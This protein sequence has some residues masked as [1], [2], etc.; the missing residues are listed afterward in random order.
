MTSNMIIVIGNRGHDMQSPKSCTARRKSYREGQVE[1]IRAWLKRRNQKEE[2]SQ[3]CPNAT[4]TSSRARNPKIPASLPSA[5]SLESPKALKSQIT[6][7]LELDQSL[8]LGIV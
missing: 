2:A 4:P 5:K 1:S 7:H 6:R 3:M 8:D